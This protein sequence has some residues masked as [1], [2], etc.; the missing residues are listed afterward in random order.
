MRINRIQRVNP[1][2]P[3]ASQ[4]DQRQSD[5]DL[6]SD[7]LERPSEADRDRKRPGSFR[8]R[9]VGVLRQSL[10]RA[11]GYAASAE[12]EEETA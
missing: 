7:D 10:R 12:Q 5:A 6:T 1:I 4:G 3:A 8:S 9:V 2:S 11:A